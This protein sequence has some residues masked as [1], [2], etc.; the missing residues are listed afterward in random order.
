MA[1]EAIAIARGL[2]DDVLAGEAVVRARAGSGSCRAICPPRWPGPTRRSRW[3]GRPGSPAARP[4]A[5]TNRSTFK[6]EAGDLQ[7][8]LAD[9]QEVLALARASGDNYVLVITLVNLGVDQVAAGEFQAGVAYLEEALKIAEARRYQHATAGVAANLGFAYLLNGDIASA[10]R[11]LSGSWTRPGPP[12]RRPSCTLPSSAWRSPSAATAIPPS[13]PSCTAPPSNSTSGPGRLSTP[14][15]EGLR[16]SDHARLLDAL[17]QA[18]FDAARQ[19][20]RALS[21]ADA[22]ALALSTAERSRARARRPVPAARR[23]PADGRADPLSAR[24]RQIMALLAGGAGNAKIAE[25]L[26][27]TPNTVR[28]HLDRIR[29]KTGARN[30]AELTRYAIQAGIE[31]VDPSP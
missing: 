2:A 24:E 1:D 9:P 15:N 26:F 14:S 27:V 29:D 22:I 20:G 16:A 11:P 10:R 17:G 31:P 25:T 21:Q 12:V 8:A 30:R 3:P 18:A 28:T 5:L 7:A 19:R 23:V 13:R 6:G 4:A